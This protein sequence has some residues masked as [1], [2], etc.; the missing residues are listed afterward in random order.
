MK[1]LWSI[2]L[3]SVR[4]AE[5][6]SATERQRTATI[7]EDSGQTGRWAQRQ[8]AY[9][10][11]STNSH[12]RPTNSASH[13]EVA[14]ATERPLLRGDRHSSHAAVSFES[15]PSLARS[16]TSFGMTAGRKNEIFR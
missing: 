8:D 9:V 3:W 16:L 14:A 12:E 13:P 6:H 2:D 4:P 10:P 11:I 5:L 7:Q 15:Q 1:N